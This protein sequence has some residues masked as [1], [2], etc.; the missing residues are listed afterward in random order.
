MVIDINDI[1]VKT[2]FFAYD[3][4]NFKMTILIYRFTRCIP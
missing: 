2:M 4:I 3:R 1:K